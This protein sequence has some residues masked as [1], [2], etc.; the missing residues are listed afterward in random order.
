ME[1]KI[2]DEV[3]GKRNGDDYYIFGKVVWIK[4]LTVFGKVRYRYCVKVAEAYT[5]PAYMVGKVVEFNRSQIR[6]TKG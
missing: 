1:I 5:T 4:Q 6:T 3:M 2:N